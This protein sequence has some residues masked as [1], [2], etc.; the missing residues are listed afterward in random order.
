M[1]SAATETITRYVFHPY[2]GLGRK[3][4]GPHKRLDDV[5][6]ACHARGFLVEGA[7]GSGVSCNACGAL[8]AEPGYYHIECN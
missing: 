1:D 8:V 7:D 6:P 5:C 4:C 3:S 2:T